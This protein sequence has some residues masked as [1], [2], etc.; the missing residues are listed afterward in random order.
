MDALILA[1]SSATYEEYL[2]RCS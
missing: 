1:P 2:N